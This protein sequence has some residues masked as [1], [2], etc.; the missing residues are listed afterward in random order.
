MGTLPSSSASVKV[1]TASR[2]A[3]G[4]PRVSVTIRFRAT[5][6]TDVPVCVDQRRRVR[7]GQPAELQGGQVGRGPPVAVP[8]PQQE[9]HALAAKAARGEQQR[10][11]RWPVK[12]VRV[13]DD[14]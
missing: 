5:A 12:P 4:L 14:G 8:R 3:S 10:L 6:A 7:G 13:V 2:I 9:Q 11:A 1:V